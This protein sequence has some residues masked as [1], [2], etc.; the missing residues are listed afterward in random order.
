MK[1]NDIPSDTAAEVLKHE[2]E[3]MT[4]YA[5]NIEGQLRRLTTTLQ[6]LAA[7]HTRVSDVV[8][9]YK[10]ILSPFRRLPGEILSEIFL[11]SVGPTKEK[12]ALPKPTNSIDSSQGA[13]VLSQVSSKWRAVALS[14][15]RLWS[16]VGL[17]LPAPPGLDTSK[18]EM[19]LER[20]G[21]YP[22]DVYIS[23]KWAKDF[24]RGHPL[25]CLLCSQSFRW[26]RARLQFKLDV[27]SDSVLPIKSKLPTLQ[28]L[29]LDPLAPDFFAQVPRGLA[30]F[31]D[32]PKLTDLISQFDTVNIS[33]F[34][35]PWSQIT[36]WSN[37]NLETD[38][39]TVLHVLAE[40]WDNLQSLSLTF[41]DSRLQ[42]TPTLLRMSQ[43]HTLSL[44]TERVGDPFLFQLLD[45]LTVP[46]LRALRLEA[47]IS[48]QPSTTLIGIL[49]EFLERSGCRLEVLCLK[50]MRRL[51]GPTQSVKD[52]DF[53]AF[54]QKEE[55]SC[56]RA[57]TLGGGK[58]KLN[59]YILEALHPATVPDPNSPEHRTDAGT[60]AYTEGTNILLPNLRELSLYVEE[61]AE[62]ESALVSILEILKTRML[63]S[64][65]QKLRTLRLSRAYR[66][67]RN[68][69]SATIHSV[70]STLSTLSGA[71]NP[72]EVLDRARYQLRQVRRREQTVDDTNS[73]ERQER[74]K[75]EQGA[76]QSLTKSLEDMGLKLVFEDKMPFEAFDSIMIFD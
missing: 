24:L 76:E 53:T 56:L 29:I 22:L 27:F 6:L 58:F 7:E 11:A 17:E 67:D 39:K 75:G 45:T 25:L 61:I 71:Q 9:N 4:G 52:V 40:G 57:L 21:S 20:S 70:L 28:C 54:F 55:V 32:A 19:Q 1:C 66:D 62:N 73:G 18:L 10:G 49:S 60:E 51:S 26:R 37:P 31:H 16:Y 34:K 63:A 74:T 14:D 36:H 64:P 46:N 50:V 38:P 72:V 8:S 23:S 33:S 13:W 43:L 42:T 15:S 3:E 41:A 59:E 47:P 69:H 2:L 65:G 44:A 48:T 12:L 30:V 5:K 68:R 35:L